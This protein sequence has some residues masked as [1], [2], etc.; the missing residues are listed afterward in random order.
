MEKNKRVSEVDALVESIN[1]NDGEQ[2]QRL[3]RL[4]RLVKAGKRTRNVGFSNGDQWS[5]N[6]WTGPDPMDYE[7]HIKR[8]Q[9]GIEGIN[10]GV[11]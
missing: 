7:R 8:L 1:Q 2:M 5:S 6:C 4:F 3:A 9:R 11:D 10:P